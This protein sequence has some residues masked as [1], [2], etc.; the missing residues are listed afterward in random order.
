MRAGGGVVRRAYRQSL[1]KHNRPGLIVVSR[2]VADRF[3]IVPAANYKWPVDVMK[4][5]SLY[6]DIRHPLDE[7][8]S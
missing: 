2:A 5:S 7:K 4:P 8:S 3:E 1:H 6:G